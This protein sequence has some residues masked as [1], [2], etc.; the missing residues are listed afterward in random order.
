MAEF[1]VA[2]C[3]PAGSQ[4]SA[5]LKL[6]KRAKATVG[7]LPDSAFRDRAARGT[8]LV[9][10]VE[11]EVAA[12]VMYDLP[13]R[14]VRIRQ[15]VTGPEH[16]HRGH[17]KSL[18]DELVRRHGARDG[19]YLECRR[20]FDVSS[21]WP[22]LGFAPIEEKAGRS[23]ARLPLTIW[24]RSFGN[25]TLLSASTNPG[26]LP[27]AALDT[28]IVVDLA[29]GTPGVADRLNSEWTQNTAGIG[30]T[31]HVLVEINRHEDPAVRAHR[32][33]VASSLQKLD[34]NEERWRTML[35]ELQTAHPDSARFEDDFIHAAK[36]ASAGA[37]W[38]VTRDGCFSR[39]HKETIRS[40]CHIEVVSPGEYLTS[41]DR[42]LRGDGYRPSDLAGS[43]LELGTLGPSQFEEAARL[44]VNQ[45]EGEELKRLRR[46]LELIA[47]DVGTTR[48]RTIC[49]GGLPIGLIATRE[50]VS[51]DIELCR[52]GPSNPRGDTI[53]RQ[54]VAIAR[55]D[56]S[57]SDRAATRLID[58]HCGAE[59]RTAARSEG[60]LPSGAEFVAMPIQ[61]YGSRSELEA[62]MTR[63]ARRLG[64]T[65]LPNDFRTIATT[66]TAS[67][68]AELLFHPWRLTQSELPTFVVPI[69][70]V[71]ASEL[72][73]IELARDTLLP[74]STG[75]TL[76]RE[77]VYYR[78]P[79]ASG[80]L[81]APGRIVW[82]VKAKKHHPGGLRAVSTLVE[83]VVDSPSRLYQRFRHLGVY[84]RTTVMDSARNDRVMA[85]HFTHTT[86]F[87][88]PIGLAQYRDLMARHGSGLLLQGPQAITEHV[89]DDLLASA[90]G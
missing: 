46:H 66:T 39:A 51:L 71:W 80:G 45:R 62:A 41:V 9:V 83:V 26:D 84:D 6:S 55:D 38:L 63:N 79:M 10:L 14:E 11:G 36:A 15:L 58:A 86:A 33:R 73:D 89:F 70:P 49:D 42:I 17:A 53:A 7:F 29:D 50:G 20:D 47:R 67:H 24:Y 27:V 77:L 16:V 1:V 81:R 76:Q 40:I 85:L 2:E 19:I 90:H 13:R 18:I 56:A 37:K 69:E 88:T 28:N 61:G 21:V 75:L 32:R 43:A 57:S 3:L 78:S 25:P 35:H 72:F 48:I 59:V 52:V 30:I 74:R 8:L 82:Y 87:P 60:F 44:F 12:Y 34:A 65:S 54:L 68:A 22:K 23:H 5:V 31:D 64:S 4:F